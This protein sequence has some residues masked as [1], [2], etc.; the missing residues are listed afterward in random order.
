MSKIKA[1]TFGLGT[2]C[3]LMKRLWNTYAVLLLMLL[4][5][6]CLSGRSGVEGWYGHVEHFE[7]WYEL[8]LLSDQTFVYHWHEGLNSGITRGKWVWE[9][10]RAVLNSYTPPPLPALVVEESIGADLDSLYLEAVDR[11]GDPLGLGLWVLNDTLIL[12]ADL[13]GK[14]VIK[15]RPVQTIKLYYLGLDSLEHDAKSLATNRFKFLVSMELS[16]ER[17]FENREGRLSARGLV[18][19][20]D[21][22]KGEM[23]MRMKRIREGG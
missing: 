17:S 6:G 18:L 5:G 14:V 7:C 11:S 3:R 21:K 22:A 19:K 15:N 2:N 9:G 8:E 12:V 20:G 10:N 13:E 1:F 23:N 4:L 16:P